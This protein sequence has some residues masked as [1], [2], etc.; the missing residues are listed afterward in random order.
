M[1]DLK[2]PVIQR[3]INQLAGKSADELFSLAINKLIKEEVQKN[4]IA[5][6]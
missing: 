4:N 6:N 1:D 3:K 2:S 5:D